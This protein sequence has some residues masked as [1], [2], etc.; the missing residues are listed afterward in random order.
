WVVDPASN[1]YYRWLFVISAAVLYNLTLIIAR[2]V[3]WK[4][5]DNYSTWWFVLDYICDAI[6][7]MDMFV[8]LRTGYLEQGLMVKEV[9][10]LRIHYTKSWTFKVDVLCILPSDLFYLAIGGNKT[11]VRMNRLFKYPRLFEFID[12]TDSHTNHPNVFRIFNLILYILIIIHWNACFFFQMSS[13]IGFGTDSWVYPNVSTPDNGSL[14]RMYI[15]SFYWSTLTL[16][17]IGETPKPEIDIEYLFVVVDF[18]IGVLIFA[19]IVGNIGSMISNMNASKA[20]FQQQMDG[21][22]RYMDLSK[23]G[24]DLEKRV[25]KW[26]D[27]V[28]TNKQTMNGEDILTNLPDKLRAEIAIHVH[29][30]TL[31]RVSI[32]Q[33]CEPGLLVQ[34]VLKLKPSVFSPGDYVCR[35][36]DIGKEMYIIKKGKLSVVADDGKTVYA[37][38]GEGGVFGEVSLLNIPGNLTGNRRTANVCSIGYSD[39]FILS[40]EDLWES[41]T[42]YPDAKVKLFERGKDILMKDELLDEEAAAQAVVIEESTQDRLVKLETTVDTLTTRFGRLLGEFSSSQAKVKRRLFQLEKKGHIDSQSLCG[43]H[44]DSYSYHCE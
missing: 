31:R 2:S 38:L 20:E 7:L 40:K 30:K 27:Y 19:T 10:K 1:T 18:L 43:F 37:T 24:K 9:H 16:T 14:A 12:R 13:W 42:E 4:L 35:K 34:L 39:L 22:K 36:G 32:F 5:Q 41:L 33:D 17:T 21:V 23:V 6:Y 3:F 26:F 8:Q 28:W 29:L 11:F 25:I 44:T 15:Y